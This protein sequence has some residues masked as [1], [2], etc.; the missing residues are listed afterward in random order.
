MTNASG[1][2]AALWRFPV[3][4]MLGERLDRTQVTDHGLHGDRAFALYDRETG[5]RVSAVNVRRYPNLFAFSARFIRPPQWGEDLPPVVIEMPDGS[6]VESGD[7]NANR[8]ISEQLGQDVELVR[9]DADGAAHHDAYPVS[10]LTNSTLRR[11][12]ELQPGS[13]FDARRFRMNV[14]VEY[15]EDGFPENGWVGKGMTIGE[16]ARLDVVLPDARCI[17]TTLAQEDLSQDRTI[18]AGLVKHNRLQIG[19]KGRYPCAGVYARVL[20]TGEIM[21]GDAV[22]VTAD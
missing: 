16:R 20:S 13:A 5:K 8:A 6:R 4:S 19:D 9:A 2:V 1:S 21:L 14:I 18:L 15:P 3:K 7:P 22:T 17:M 12:N 11:M 10:V